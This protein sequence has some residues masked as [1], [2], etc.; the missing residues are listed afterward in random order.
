MNIKTLTE[1]E[2][3]GI[4]I[5]GLMLNN[6]VGIYAARIIPIKNMKKEVKIVGP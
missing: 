6:D 4:E 5:R 2:E 3:G 1:S